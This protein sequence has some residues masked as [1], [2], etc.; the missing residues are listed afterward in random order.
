MTEQTPSTRWGADVLSLFAGAAVEH[1][2]KVIVP[3]PS[4]IKINNTTQHNP[5]TINHQ[6]DPTSDVPDEPSSNEDDDSNDDDD[7]LTSSSPTSFNRGRGFSSDGFPT[8]RPHPSSSNKSNL[9]DQISSE[10]ES[11]ES[12]DEEDSS[13]HAMDTNGHHHHSNH[14]H[15][16]PNPTSLKRIEDMTKQDITQELRV[17]KRQGK[18]TGVVSGAR[19]FLTRAIACARAGILEPPKLEVLKANITIRRKQDVEFLTKVQMQEELKER[20][21]LRQYNGKVSGSREFLIESLWNCVKEQMREAKMERER[22]KAEAQ[23]VK[24]E[25]LARLRQQENLKKQMLKSIHSKNSKNLKIQK[26][27]RPRNEKEIDLL[28]K[29]QMIA[30]LQTR[31]DEGL[32]N[33]RMTGTRKLLMVHLKR[34]IHFSRTSTGDIMDDRISKKKKSSTNGSNNKRARDH[35]SSS[36]SSGTTATTATSM[37]PSNKVQKMTHSSSRA[38]SPV[39]PIRVLVRDREDPEFC[40]ECGK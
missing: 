8:P 22:I 20:K 11:S 18:Y 32:Y 26:R 35:S 23:A 19:P 17:L 16:H 14:R 27:P 6:S 38:S 34:A 12:N 13:A 36:S 3:P 5:L 25:A 40:V 30:E 31:K 15:H 2:D 9:S 21:E 24:D 7:D 33:G 10:E 28:T 1:A 39:P 29:A 4:S 37:N